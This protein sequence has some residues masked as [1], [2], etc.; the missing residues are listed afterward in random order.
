MEKIR[1]RDKCPSGR[2]FFHRISD[3][4]QSEKRFRI[5]I[6]VMWIRNTAYWGT[7]KYVLLRTYGTGTYLRVYPRDLGGLRDLSK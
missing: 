3:P 2:R 5:R 7:R 1:I 4:H 6:K